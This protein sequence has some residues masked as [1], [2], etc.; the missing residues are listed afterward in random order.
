MFKFRFNEWNDTGI[1]KKNQKKNS[2]ILL[3]IVTIIIFLTIY[4]LIK[5]PFIIDK[6]ILAVSIVVQLFVILGILLQNYYIFGLSNIL[7]TIIVMIGSLFFRDFSVN[8]F[9]IILLIF[10]ILTR[11]FLNGCLFK[12]ATNKTFPSVTEFNANW[13]Y[14]IFLMIILFR[15]KL[16]TK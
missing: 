4:F 16:N 13:Y 1:D 11:Y 5:T 2:K 12:I 8:I 9:L 7:Y 6:C 3:I 14:F 15:L 10:T